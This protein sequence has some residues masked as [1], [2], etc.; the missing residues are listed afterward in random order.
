MS[1]VC[2]CVVLIVY[3]DTLLLSAG[4]HIRLTNGKQAVNFLP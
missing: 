1:H 4:M 2:C 3:E